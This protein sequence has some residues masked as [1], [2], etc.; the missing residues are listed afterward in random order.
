MEKKLVCTLAVLM[1]ISGV[2]F[3]QSKKTVKEK[4]ISSTTVHEYFL[5]EGM[6]K[7]VVESIEK[8]NENGDLIEIQAFNKKGEVKKWEK[9]SY[10]SDGNLE[11]EV[12][13][14][15]KGRVTLTEKNIYQDGLRIEKQYYNTR[16]DLYK[17]KVYK[18]DYHE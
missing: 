15:T 13:M 10:D 7:P 3:S 11:E 2:A 17:K 14:D 16:G 9:Y 18:Y 12:F 5:G 6:K 1:I 4:K 8:F